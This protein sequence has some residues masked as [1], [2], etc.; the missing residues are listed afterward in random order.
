V[1]FSNIQVTAYTNL[2]SNGEEISYTI[3]MK[4]A[5]A[6]GSLPLS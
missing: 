3:G 4:E 2:K 5:I 6:E 1:Q